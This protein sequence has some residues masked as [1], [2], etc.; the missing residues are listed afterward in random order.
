M[1]PEALKLMANQMKLLNGYGS[2]AGAL[3]FVPPAEK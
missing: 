2:Q 1:S 3:R